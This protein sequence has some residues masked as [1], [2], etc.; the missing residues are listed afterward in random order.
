MVSYTDQ[1][2]VNKLKYIKRR[3]GLNIM[4]VD[5]QNNLNVYEKLIKTYKSLLTTIDSSVYNILLIEILLNDKN[6]QL[7]K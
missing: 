1:N 5:L 2:K 3:V 7:P 4:D 6:W